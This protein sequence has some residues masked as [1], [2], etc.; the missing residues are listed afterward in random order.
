MARC[1]LVAR[2]VVRGLGGQDDFAVPV[3]DVAG[4]I[5]AIVIAGPTPA[6][7]PATGWLAMAGTDALVLGVGVEVDG[8]GVGVGELDDDDDPGLV[9]DGEPEW[10]GDVVGVADGEGPGR[11][12]GKHEGL[13]LWPQG[14]VDPPVP[15][16]GNGKVERSFKPLP[17]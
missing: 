4:F 13:R 5:S 7:P 11:I 15:L 17:P 16:L 9:G 3:A 1:F 10:L 8:V 12:S 14:A 6:L 2:F